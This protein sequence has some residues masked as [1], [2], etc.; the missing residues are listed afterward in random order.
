MI[1]IIEIQLIRS[2]AKF[3]AF[4]MSK[5]QAENSRN[6]RPTFE[7]F[8]SHLI[9]CVQEKK[10]QSEQSVRE[11]RSRQHEEAVRGDWKYQVELR[12]RR[13]TEERRREEAEARD[14]RAR[15]AIR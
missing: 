10:L 4:L 1:M 7:P 6:L 5:G 9:R 3:L 14:E 2:L 12:E 15:E 13:E 8:I 11:E